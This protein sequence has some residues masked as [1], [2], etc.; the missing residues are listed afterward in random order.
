[1]SVL[2]GSESV[3][4]TAV[5]GISS[6]DNANIDVISLKTGERKNLLRGAFCSH[7]LP[8]AGG[9]PMLVYLRQGT[10]FASPLRSDW[11]L[12]DPPEVIADGIAA[13]GYAGGEFVVSRN[14][15]LVYV[16]GKSEPARTIAWVDRTGA[17]R[18]FYSIPGMYFTPRL[19]ADGK[20]L[21]FAMGSAQ[22]YDI[23]I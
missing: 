19:S 13:S 15:T 23:W 7:Y 8:V 17:K 3:L 10:L 11:T 20:R 22:T 9:A 4:F 6:Y 16:Q 1:P 5:T 21:A 12:G 14:G 2:P 18:P